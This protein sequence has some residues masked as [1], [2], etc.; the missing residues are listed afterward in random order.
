MKVTKRSIVIREL[1][2]DDY[3]HTYPNN[4]YDSIAEFIQSHGEDATLG[5][6]NRQYEQRQREMAKWNAKNE[7]RSRNQP[8][9][10]AK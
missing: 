1:S 10:P 7:V 2:G 6:L 3:V 4:Q 5:I 9:R 8:I